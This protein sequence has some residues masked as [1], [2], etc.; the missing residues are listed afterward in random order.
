MKFLVKLMKKQ[1]D[2]DVWVYTVRIAQWVLLASDP[3]FLFN[4]ADIMQ[5]MLECIYNG[6]IHELY[7]VTMFH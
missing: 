4:N 6:S 3:E 2:H 5:T 7:A 1:T